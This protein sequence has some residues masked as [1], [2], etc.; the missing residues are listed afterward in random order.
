M[1]RQMILLVVLARSNNSPFRLIAKLSMVQTSGKAAGL[2]VLG[3]L[4]DYE[5]SLG[6]RVG[7]VLGGRSHRPYRRCH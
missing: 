7:K 5:G 6:R 1:I 4:S 2:V 3:K